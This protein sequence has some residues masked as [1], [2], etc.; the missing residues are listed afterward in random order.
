MSSNL[1][2]CPACGGQLSHARQITLC[3]ACHGSIMAAS[4]ARVSSTGEFAALSMDAAN[5][6]LAETP[7]PPAQPSAVLSCTWCS[8]PRDQVK[9]LLQGNQVSICNECVAL[10]T[11]I[12]SAELGDDWR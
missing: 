9:K 4:T 6:L 12:M 5:A 11:D 8:K 2:P 10:C 3:G 7:A 1:S